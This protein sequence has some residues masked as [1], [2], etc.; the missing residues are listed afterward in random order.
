MTV[1]LKKVAYEKSTKFHAEYHLQQDDHFQCC[2]IL[3][4]AILDSLFRK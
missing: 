1:A 2:I 4:E 3:L